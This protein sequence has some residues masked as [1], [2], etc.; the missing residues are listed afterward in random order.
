[1]LLASQL[2]LPAVIPHALS[3]QHHTLPTLLH[4]DLA[5]YLLQGNDAPG[6]PQHIS[7]TRAEGTEISWVATT[8]WPVTKSPAS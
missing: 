5:T 8:V 7:S 4:S 2:A 3:S 1:M 6:F